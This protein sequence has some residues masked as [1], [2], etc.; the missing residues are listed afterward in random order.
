[1]EDA[2]K[3]IANYE[4]LQVSTMTIVAHTNIVISDSQK[5]FNCLPITNYEIKEKK[6][7]RKK[8]I[9]DPVV[10]NNLQPGSIVFLEYEMNKKG[11]QVKKKRDTSKKFFRNSVT[12]VIAVED[13]RLTT[14]LVNIKISKNG[15]FQITG[16]RSVEQVEKSVI[17][18]WNQM[19]KF[20]DIYNFV[21]NDRDFTITFIPAMRNIDFQLN[22]NVDREKFDDFFNKETRFDSLLDT[23]AGYAGINLKAP[24][25]KPISELVLKIMTIKDGSEE[26][27]F[28]QKTYQ[29]YLDGLKVKD[30]NMKTKKK[31]S[32]TF[33][34]FQSGQVILTSLNAEYAKPVFEEFVRLVFKNKDRLIEQIDNE[35]SSDT[36]DY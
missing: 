18:I 29:D 16:C 26:I 8:K 31:R 10:E 30:R 17:Y 21:G 20:K 34:V 11:V 23:S 15:S 22:F 19:K 27:V 5:L 32:H 28:S 33:L 1:M 7:G 35:E 4:K 12:I 6:R 3:L 2:E 13:D 25:D 24:F 9:V 36:D 14:K